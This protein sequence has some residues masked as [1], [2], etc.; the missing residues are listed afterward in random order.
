MN[1]EERILEVLAQIQQDLSGVKQDVSDLK[2]G[3]AVVEGRLSHLEHIQKHFQLSIES[4][5]RKQIAFEGRLERLEKGQ[6]KLETGQAEIKKEM[7]E[8]NTN[9]QF[10]WEDIGKIGDRL[11]V[12]EDIVRKKLM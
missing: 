3:Q 6:T 12:Q 10:M 1:N 11:G 8:M 7:E 2:T 5:D 9:I 4:I